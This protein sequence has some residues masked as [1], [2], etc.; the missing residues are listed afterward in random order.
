MLGISL[1][2]MLSHPLKTSIGLVSSSKRWRLPSLRPCD[3]STSCAWWDCSRTRNHGLPSS[4]LVAN[5]LLVITTE[6]YQRSHERIAWKNSFN[7]CHINNCRWSILVENCDAWYLTSTHV[8]SSSE[9]IHRA[10][11]KFKK[12]KPT[13]VSIVC[14]SNI[15]LISHELVCSWCASSL[16]W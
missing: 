4:Y 2:P 3:W 11:L 13:A 6:R 7:A 1:P 9:N 5:S 12:P 8:V 14:L 10:G 16:S 15:S